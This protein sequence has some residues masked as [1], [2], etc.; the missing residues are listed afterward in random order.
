MQQ[1]DVNAAEVDD[2]VQSGYDYSPY[3]DYQ[4]HH[5][6]D[7]EQ[8]VRQKKQTLSGKHH[9]RSQ[10]RTNR[11]KT[12]KEEA[13]DVSVSP[14]IPLNYK[15]VLQV[16]RSSFLLDEREPGSNMLKQSD[17]QQSDPG[18]PVTSHGRKKVF[19]SAF[20]QEQQRHAKAADSPRLPRNFKHDDIP[21]VKHGED[22]EKHQEQEAD[23][24]HK[25]LDG[26]S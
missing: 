19:T 3:S 18:W 15:P 9:Q 6:V 20:Q 10:G 4:P 2:V 26:H 12:H 14:G 11:T 21:A 23:E 7:Q 16:S 25:R 17:Q 5:S 22:D 24:K 13:E 1:T 8:Q